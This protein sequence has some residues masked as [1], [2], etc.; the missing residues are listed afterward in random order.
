MREIGQNLDTTKE[1]VKKL[2]NVPV[3]IKIN[4]G[5][6]KSTLCRGEVTALF[7]AVFSVKLDSGELKTF[8]YADVHTRGVLFLKPQK[9]E[10]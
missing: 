2:L 8:S 5:R 6:G 1:R 10:Q 7:P 4:S 3:L 9:Q